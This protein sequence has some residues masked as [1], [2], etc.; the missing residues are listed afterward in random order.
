M[1]KAKYGEAKVQDVITPQIPDKEQ[2]GNSILRNKIFSKNPWENKITYFNKAELINKN[3][4]STSKLK[5][6]QVDARR[7]EK[8]VE[9]NND[10]AIQTVQGFGSLVANKILLQNTTVKAVSDNQNSLD[11]SFK[12]KIGKF[13]FKKLS[14]L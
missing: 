5:T 1:I 14:N 3:S 10:I 11:E 7:E 4:A 9:T 12:S 8:F 2:S 6:E 13:C